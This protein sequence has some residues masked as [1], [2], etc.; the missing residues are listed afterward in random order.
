MFTFWL[1]D[2][3][4]NF[5]NKA[6]CSCQQYNESNT[7]FFPLYCCYFFVHSKGFLFEIFHQKGFFLSNEFYFSLVKGDEMA[8]FKFPL[9]KL[10]QCEDLTIK[11]QSHELPDWKG[12]I[13]FAAQLRYLEKPPEKSNSFFHVGIK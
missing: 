2:R 11:L 12:R 13:R 9:S 6:K 10:V 4:K 8:T 3:R 7:L 5:V 1:E